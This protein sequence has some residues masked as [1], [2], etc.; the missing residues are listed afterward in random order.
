M[1]WN[2]DRIADACQPGMSELCIVYRRTVPP[3]IFHV[4]PVCTSSYLAVYVERYESL[5]FG[6]VAST[7]RA[8]SWTLASMKALWRSGDK[9][10]D[11]T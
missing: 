3:T 7:K 8:A 2:I 11:S 10:A 9:A 4:A 5:W 1:D 6:S